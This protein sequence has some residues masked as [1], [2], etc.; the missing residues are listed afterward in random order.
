MSHFILAPVG[1][2]GDVLP[3]VWLGRHLQQRG[4][5]VT[6]IASCLTE[7]IVRD[8]GLGFVPIGTHEEFEALLANP[9]LWHPKKGLSLVFREMSKWTLPYFEAI[10]GLVDDCRGSLLVAQGIAFGARLAREKLGLRLITVHLQPAAFISMH[11]TP[12][13]APKMEWFNRLPHFV[14]RILFSLA[15]PIDQCAGPAIKAACAALG[16]PPPRRVMSDWWHSPDGV[17]ALFPAWYAAPQPDW[18]RGTRMHTFPLEDL[19]KEQPMSDELKTFL[20][21]GGKPVVFT[22]GSAMQ[23]A[24]EF[25]KAA[26][27]ACETLR[28]RAVFATGHREHL[29][30]R[31][32]ESVLAVDYVPFGQVLP[33]AAAFVHHGGVGTLAQGLA[34]GVPQLVMPMAHDQPDNA[35]RLRR[36]GVGT[37]LL[38]EDFN[39]ENV[40]AALRDLLRDETVGAACRRC[41]DLVRD[42]PRPYSLME[43]LERQVPQASQ[44]A[45]R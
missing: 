29:P 41:A 11:D 15:S 23:H 38:P 19:A 31:L 9:D 33:S 21:S 45:S 40:A 36:L 8:A 2:A 20:A 32:P 42:G 10:K 18:P 14:K 4:H 13:L 34:A 26:L 22:P 37:S 28:L 35:N 12:V 24:H 30:P 6:L 7:K 17:L 39:V 3:F 27:G 44:L 1:S 5:R 25:F 43:W 16:M